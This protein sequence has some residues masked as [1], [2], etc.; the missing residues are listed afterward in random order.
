MSA[1]S[2]SEDYD[3]KSSTASKRSIHEGEPP[4][5]VDVHL[6]NNKNCTQTSHQNCIAIVDVKNGREPLCCAA[7][8]NR[9]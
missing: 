7:H 9:L 6:H 2:I 8:Y 5:L 3:T 1:T 4:A